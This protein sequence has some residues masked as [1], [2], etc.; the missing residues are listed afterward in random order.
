[1]FFTLSNG[2]RVSG[3]SSSSRRLSLLRSC[4]SVAVIALVAIP[5][6]LTAQ[7]VHLSNATTQN[8]GSVNVGTASAPATLTFTFDTAGTLGGTA[9]V[10]QGATGLDFTDAGTGSCSAGQSYA[11]GATCTINVTFMPTRPWARYGAALLYDGSGTPIATA[12]LQGIGLGPQVNFLPGTETAIPIY[13]LPA[14]YTLLPSS[15]EG[16]AVD[17]SGNLFIGDPGYEQLQELTPEGGT[18]NRSMAAPGTAITGLAVDGAGNLYETTW[19]WYT[20]F[21]LSHLLQ[22]G[23]EVSLLGSVGRNNP[24]GPQGITIDGSGNVYIVDSINN[25][26]VKETL[27]DGTYTQSVLL[28]GHQFSGVAVDAGGNLYISA[29]DSSQVLTLSA[30]NTQGVI[31]SGFQGAS[32]IAIDGMGN[33]YVTDSTN[34]ALVK[35]TLSGGTYTQSTVATSPLSDPIGVAI[36]ASG[37]VYV[38]DYFNDR[39][40]IENYSNPPSLTFVATPPGT[41]SYDSPETAI[42]ENIG[43]APLNFPVAAT[44]SNPSISENFTLDSSGA[45]A[46]PLVSAGAATAGT[47]AAGA[48]CQ[49]RVSYSPTAA[50]PLTGTVAL[51]DNN[52]NAA[53]PSYSTQ[54]VLLAGGVKSSPQFFM[55]ASAASLNQGQP[56]T[57]TVSV[58][59]IAGQL[60][61]T[62]TVTISASS[63]SAPFTS[64]T[65]TLN[66]GG[67]ATWSSSTLTDG[68]YQ[69]TASYSGDQKYNSVALSSP[70]VFRVIGLPAI[71]ACNQNY[72]LPL[73]YGGNMDGGLDALVTDSAGFGL[74][75]VAVT[76][77]GADLVYQYPSQLSAFGG[78]VYSPLTAT[79]GGVL[80]ATVTASGIATPATCPIRVLPAPL[81]V[82]V[83][84]AH[85]LRL[86]GAANPEFTSTV[87]GLVNGDTLEGTVTVSLSTT[88]TPASA[89]GQYPVTVTLGGSS[90][91]Y[92]TVTA[93]GNTLKVLPAPLTIVAKSEAL[94]YG[95][96]PTLPL[97]YSLYGFANG[98]NSSV[99]SGAPVLTTNVTS[100]TPHG[101]YPIDVQVGTLT[102]SNYRFVT[103]GPPGG[104]AAVQVYKAPLTVTANTVTMTEGGTV[105]ALSYTITGFVNG[106]DA[107]VVSGSATLTTT[108]TA[109]TKVGE[110]PIAVN[111]SGLS[112]ENYYFEPAVHGG[113]VKVVK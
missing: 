88:A 5:S 20:A 16:I 25:R 60:V 86:Y 64:Q 7:T 103:S 91:G 72:T 58:A 84:P 90:G 95:Q 71:V 29:F 106:E 67:T 79:T 63:G 51:T 89:V 23:Y 33:L 56:V 74:N 100:T 76:L 80:T 3:L 4:L 83:L 81:T 30:T 43:N 14:P 94:T 19:F 77:G 61:P 26:I 21:K 59:G 108:V 92:Y 110:Y 113:V 53:A 75:G 78:E 54:S 36:D 40:L 52:L 50:T 45:S 105:P 11:A 70:V 46:C 6:L 109:G 82:R 49:L 31:G 1:M 8:F 62:G 28:T 34:N 41:T 104:V 101:T 97:G 10:T 48:F 69:L 55:N 22:G 111:V 65:L 47:L 44:G 35:E 17:A 15:P 2:S 93:I 87:S 107:S 66:S 57:L 85:T 27:S 102:A 42:V 32:S 12:Y 39:V 24:D 9:V 18:F 13:D 37:S 96:S 112:A 98:E 73:Q 99:V 68:L 38:A